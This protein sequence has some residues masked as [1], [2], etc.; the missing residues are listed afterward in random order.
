MVG[1]T[2]GFIARPM[3]IRAILNGLISAVIA[4]VL[5]FV[6]IQWA[7]RQ[8]PQ[9]DTYTGYKTYPYIIWRNDTGWCGD[10]T[11]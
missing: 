2:R 7:E 9:L 11:I 3:D 1:A 10:F 5:L 6:L 8:F 4:I